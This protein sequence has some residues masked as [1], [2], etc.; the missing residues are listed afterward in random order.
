V[1]E[2]TTESETIMEN[3]LAF[4]EVLEAADQLSL[5]EQ[6]TLADILKRRIIERRRQE[7]AADVQSARREYGAGSCEA[8]T[9]DEL[10]TE[11]LV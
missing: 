11:I 1:P 8:V 9:T 6:E 5:E 10:M 3:E 2:L 4:G 7:L